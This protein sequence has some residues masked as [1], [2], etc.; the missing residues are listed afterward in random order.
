MR[1]RS[2]STSTSTFT[3]RL[4]AEERSLFE[5]AAQLSDRS[6]GRLIA[7]LAKPGAKAIISEAEGAATTD[8]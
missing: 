5:R 8:T 6:T 7:H 1:T 2:I 4:T 3:L